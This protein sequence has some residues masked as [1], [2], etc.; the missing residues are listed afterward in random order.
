MSPLQR[1]GRILLVVVTLAVLWSLATVLARD[2]RRQQETRAA[3]RAALGREALAASRTE[4]GVGH[5]RAAVALRPERRD[6]EL[7]LAKALLTLGRTAEAERYLLDVLRVDATNGDAQLALA[8]VQAQQSRMEEAEASYFRAIYG[9]WPADAERMRAEARLELIDLL[10]ATADR[11]RV[12]GQFIQLAASF[13][14]DRTLQMQV[15]RSLLDFGLADEAARVFQA[16]IDRFADPDVAYAGLAEAELA[17]RDYAAA[18]DA[19]RRA[20]A[21]DPADRASAAMLARATTVSGL[22]PNQPRLS[23]RERSARTRRLLDLVRTR[24]AA[25][26]ADGPLSADDQALADRLARPL[27]RAVTPMVLDEEAALLEEAARRL[28]AGCASELTDEPVD[29]ALRLVAGRGAR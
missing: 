7:D 13:P 28:L 16:S 17:R 11:D 6:Y 23:A 15:G 22:D 20:L 27:A 4:E 26:W 21:R 24:L 1:R 29:L 12:R 10:A 5:F 2:L 25:C 9:Q 18:A 14:G 3:S 8:R 19:A